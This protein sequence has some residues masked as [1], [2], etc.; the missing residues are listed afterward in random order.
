MCFHTCVLIC[1]LPKVPAIKEVPYASGYMSVCL[2]LQ[3]SLY[4]SLYVSLHRKV[5]TD[6]A[7]VAFDL[8]CVDYVYVPYVCPYVCP[9]I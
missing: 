2:S 3:V 9:C 8:M 1:V 4:V 6:E 5:A 7:M